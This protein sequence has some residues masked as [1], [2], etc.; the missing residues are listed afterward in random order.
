MVDDLIDEFRMQDIYSSKRNRRA[1][2]EKYRRN[3]LL[4]I[5]A[6]E[7]SHIELKH[8]RSD[9]RED[10]RGLHV[11]D[12]ASQANEIKAD[13]H[14]IHLLGNFD[15]G[16]AEAYS[17]LLDITNSLIRKSV[18]P[19]TFPD[20]C[21]KMPRGVG[22][23]FDYQSDAKPIR[24]RLAGSHPE[25]VARFLRILYVASRDTSQ[26][27]TLGALTRRAIDQLEVE[28]EQSGWRSMTQSFSRE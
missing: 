16:P 5:L 2:Q 13:E 26:S 12:A 14:A 4:W 23:I 7:L 21:D 6:H 20:V 8:G 11:F 18:C 24:V 9:Y 15:K 27:S 28:I 25:F 22:L 17:T 1:T 10:A 19:R 3:I